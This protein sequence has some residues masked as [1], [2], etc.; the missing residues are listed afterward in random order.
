MHRSPQQLLLTNESQ[1]HVD[2]VDED[3][4]AGRLESHRQ[5]QRQFGARNHHPANKHVTQP[6]VDVASNSIKLG[7]I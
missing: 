4:I 3:V 2:L 6:R 5:R 1:D 7:T